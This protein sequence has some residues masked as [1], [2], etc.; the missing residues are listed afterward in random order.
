MY[1]RRKLY[2]NIEGEYVPIEQ[3]R[4]QKIF[5]D[6][7]TGEKLY[8]VFMTEDELRMFGEVM[9]DAARN[10]ATGVGATLGG[11]ALVGGAG[12][13]VAK[14]LDRAERKMARKRTLKAVAEKNKIMKEASNKAAAEAKKWAGENMKGVRGDRVNEAIQ[15]G[16]SRAAQV[17]VADA[18]KLEKGVAALNK[19]GKAAT[20][21]VKNNPKLAATIAAGTLVAGGAAGAGI[22][23]ARSKKNN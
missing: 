23:A 10:A 16:K 3:T 5:S 1:I 2:S 6:V 7:E 8:S 13:G 21:W 4:I 20:A 22:G 17:K 19:G 11:A 14:G 12:Y 9:E 18:G 15:T